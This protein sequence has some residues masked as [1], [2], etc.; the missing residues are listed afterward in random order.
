MKKIKNYVSYFSFF[1]LLIG[2]V[3]QSFADSQGIPSGQKEIDSLLSILKTSKDDTNKIKTLNALSR[4]Y[5]NT[6][7]Y[8]PALQDAQ[9]ALQRSEK[10]L[11]KKGMAAAYNN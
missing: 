3:K 9:E 4:L 8:E 2:G 7:N 1:L 11:Y 6:S 10:I 5:A